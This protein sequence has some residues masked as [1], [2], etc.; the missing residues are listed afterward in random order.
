[1]LCVL[2]QIFLT[3]YD[4]D[5][6]EKTFKKA[7]SI[8]PE[9]VEILSGL[10]EALEKGEKIQ[11][12][13]DAIEN[14]IAIEPENLDLQKQ[15]AGTLLSASDFEE[16]FRKID[17]LYKENEDDLQILDLYGQYYACMDDEESTNYY[18]KRIDQVDKNYKKHLLSTAK[19]FS[20]IG[21]K[22]RA[23]SYAKNYIEKHV[24]DPEGYNVL[25]KVY[26]KAGDYDNAIISY[27]K[28]IELSKD[29]IFANKQLSELLKPL[30]DSKTFKQHLC[31][32]F[33]VLLYASCINIGVESH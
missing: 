31:D 19:R 9:N 23:E 4:F 33:K 30:L 25:G 28:G 21:K 11:E 24:N 15:L 5:S 26:A 16:A 13:L 17:T 27:N 6:A 20:Q 14:A 32:L 3:Q 2:G 29:N 10:A 18:H 22:E 8:T 7:N 12:A 1:M